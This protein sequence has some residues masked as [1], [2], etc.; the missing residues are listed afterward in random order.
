MSFLRT[1]QISVRRA[2]GFWIVLATAALAVFLVSRF[3]VTEVVLW[4]DWSANAARSF[5]VIGPVFAAWSAMLASRDAKPNRVD[6]LRATAA[7]R[8]QRELGLA[9]LGILAALVCYG[10]VAAS[11]LGYAARHATWGGPDLLIVLFGGAATALFA[12]VGWLVGILVPGRLTPVL[13]G[14]GTFLY[15]VVSY[16]WGITGAGI[17][18]IQPWRYIEGRWDIANRMFFDAPLYTGMPHPAGG[19]LIALAAGAILIGG[20]LGTRETLRGVVIALV[21]GTVLL[22][23]GWVL[24]NSTVEMPLERPELILTPSM[25]C[26]G[27]VVEVCLHQAYEVQ[28]DDGVAFA[29]A[30]YEPVSSLPGVPD[31]VTQQFFARN[32]APEGTLP[33]NAGWTE[34]PIET[35]LLREMGHGLMN[36]DFGPLNASQNAILAWLSE[37][38]GERWFIGPV[39]EIDPMTSEAHFYEQYQADID[40]A[41]ERFAA[42]S[43]EEQRA[44]LEANWDALRS[45][46][47]T[48]EDLP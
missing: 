41:A 35:I 39:A 28:L 6:L 44:W 5:I 27:D 11:V 13:A 17:D 36:S 31:T 22:I 14:A 9:A 7:P 16:T 48:L 42:L 33:L 15:T 12:L 20:Y 21:T 32:D 37:E 10:I 30:F 1:M 43:P 46:E 24:A 3:T 34:T 45:G 29:E 4:R 40:A 19:V 18:A 25:S 2:F 47:L 23:P 38:A 8:L 26:G